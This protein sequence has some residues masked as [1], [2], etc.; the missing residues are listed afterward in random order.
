MITVTDLPQHFMP[1]AI[2]HQRVKAAVTLL[3]Q[4]LEDD[5]FSLLEQFNQEYVVTPHTYRM[6][7]V[8][9]DDVEQHEGEFELL[10]ALVMI[11]RPTPDA[12]NVSFEQAVQ[13]LDYLHQEYRGVQHEMFSSDAQSPAID[14]TL[15]RQVISVY[16]NRLLDQLT[17]Q[18]CMIIET[19]D[20]YP[21]HLTHVH[22][23][24]E[25]Q[26]ECALAYKQLSSAQKLWLHLKRKNIEL[27]DQPADLK[28]S[29]LCMAV[30]EDA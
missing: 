3:E 20:C 12:K 17:Q 2:D 13:L 8:E 28:I 18:H 19:F 15:E 11:P 7:D 27:K 23:D 26:T 1:P 6:L 24:I 16:L 5:D 22:S 30:L 29:P 21:Y 4:I 9:F 10:A 25:T 14:K